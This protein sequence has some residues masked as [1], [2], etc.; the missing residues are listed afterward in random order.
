M[1]DQIYTYLEKYLSPY[2][3]GFRKGYITQHCLAVMVESWKKAIDKNKH[4]GAILTDLSKAFDCLNHK[5][6]IAKLNAY[7]LNENSLLF[8]YN[9]LTERKP[10][11]K[12]NNSLSTWENIK[13][14]VPQGSILGPLLFNIYMNDIFW[15]TPDINIANYADDTT[16]YTIENNIKQLIKIL[17][18]NTEKI[19]DWYGDNY[20]KSNDDK[21]HLLITSTEEISAKVGNHHIRNSASEKLLGVTIDSKLNYNEHVSKL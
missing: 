9:Y 5:L 18:Q 4:A 11:I 13:S 20:M 19:K 8:I 15:F 1:Y 12:I 6:L 21:C 16:P 2:L 14:G 10:R 7:G 17:E 3:C